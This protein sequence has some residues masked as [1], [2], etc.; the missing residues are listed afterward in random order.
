MMGICGLEWSTTIKKS[1][2][3]YTGYSITFLDKS[4]GYLRVGVLLHLTIL[5]LNEQQDFPII[6]FL[7]IS[8]DIFEIVFVRNVLMYSKTDTFLG[9]LKCPSVLEG[10]LS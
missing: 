3:F 6:K 8:N 2:F 7:F 10:F 5:N 1:S 4:N 9:I